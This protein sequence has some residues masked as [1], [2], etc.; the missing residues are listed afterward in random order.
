M[1]ASADVARHYIDDVR[2]QFRKL[3]EL[4][5]GAVAQLSD[6]DLFASNGDESNSVA[7]VMR[8]V[9]GNLRSRFT[10][11]LTTDGE[12]PDRHRD[13]EF[14]VPADTSRET[15]VAGWDVGFTRL[16]QALDALAPADL[17]RD[18]YI[19]GQRHTVIE[20]LNRSFQ[21]TAYHVGQIVAF[22]KQRRG[23]QWRTLSIPRGQSEQFNASLRRH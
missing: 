20:A 1:S 7:I 3:Q 19:R 23:A 11:F 15:V 13:Q 6:E 8:H 2:I 12:K 21:H 16:Q 14:E 22:A 18:V 9:G 17:M 4:A 5:E 10:D